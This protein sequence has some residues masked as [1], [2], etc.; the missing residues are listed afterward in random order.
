MGLFRRNK[1][2]KLNRTDVVNAIIELEKKQSD[3]E[4]SIVEKQEQI[5]VLLA[6]GKVEKNRDMQLFYAKKI[7]SLKAQKQT[8]IQRSMFLLKNIEMMNRLKDAV[9]DKDFFL[10]AG[11]S[12]L[13]SLLEDQKGLAKYLQQAMGVRMTAE[14][15]LTGAEEIFNNVELGYEPNEA[16]YGVQSN[17]DELLAM[18]ETEKALEMESSIANADASSRVKEANSNEE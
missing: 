2:K 12:S 18:F 7:N 17:D 11:Q 8:A 6:K 10:E 4:K 15:S 13:N 1:F 3:Y 5:D 16:I 9:D 14:N